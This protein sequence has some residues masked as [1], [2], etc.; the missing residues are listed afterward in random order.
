MQAEGFTNLRLRIALRNCAAWPWIFADFFLQNPLAKPAS[1]AI[2]MWNGRHSCDVL[3]SW[4]VWI[5]AQSGRS[6]ENF[7]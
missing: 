5:S 7:V 1:K 6:P 3:P 2:G 4:R